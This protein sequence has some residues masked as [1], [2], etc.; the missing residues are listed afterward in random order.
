MQTS[1]VGLVSHFGLESLLP[2]CD[3]SRQWFRQAA[4]QHRAGCIWAVMEAG[5]AAEIAELLA[6]GESEAA[7][8]HMSNGAE[9][10]GPL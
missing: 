1:F 8:N 4:R 2:E 6:I 5:V 7:F 9:C 3:A 10:M